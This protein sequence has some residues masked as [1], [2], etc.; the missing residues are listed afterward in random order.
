MNDKT[1]SF[2]ISND[3]ISSRLHLVKA[4]RFKA[5]LQFFHRPARVLSA[6]LSP[7]GTASRES[8]ELRSLTR[9]VRAEKFGNLQHRIHLQHL[10]EP[11]KGALVSTALLDNYKREAVSSLATVSSDKKIA[12]EGQR[13]QKKSFASAT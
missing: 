10:V 8:D 5:V 7:V 6:L 4:A 9:D 12:K 1:L 11:I 2:L 13:L 3:P